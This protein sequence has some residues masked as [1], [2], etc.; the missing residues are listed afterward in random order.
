MTAHG[1]GGESPAAESPA[2]IENDIRAI[3]ARMDATLDEIEAR[4]SPAGLGGGVLDAVQEALDGRPGRIAAA[5]RD[6]P[7][8]VALMGIG[9]LWLAWAVSRTGRDGQR[10]GHQPE[11]DHRS[12]LALLSHLTEV[13]RQGAVAAR[14]LAERRGSSD[15]VE[16]RLIGLGSL[17][18]RSA[19]VL[20]HEYLRMGG[21]STPGAP[22]IPLWAGVFDAL[23][24]GLPPSQ[25][26][27]R[28]EQS[29]DRALDL[30]RDALHR[31]LPDE[32]RVIVG[33]RHHDLSAG[34]NRLAAVRE[35]VL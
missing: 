6:N 17:F 14:M 12:L 3:R 2:A 27:F 21:V 35:A 5:I 15:G 22:V 7:V 34:R 23:N 29:F 25:I 20:E 33:S 10:A 31:D 30:F 18:E 28:L 9:A 13:C 19:A 1:M 24:T 4:L 32:V 8:P 26:L 16:D 11:L